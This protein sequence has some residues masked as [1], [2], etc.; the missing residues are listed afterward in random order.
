MKHSLSH[1]GNP[2]LRT[3][4]SVAVI[5]A[6]SAA[7]PASAESTKVP[8]HKSVAATASSSKTIGKTSHSDRVE[9]RIGDLRSKLKITPDQEDKWNNVTEVMRENAQKLDSLTQTRIQTANRMT[10]V[11]DLKSYSQIADA[12]AEGLKKFIPAFQAL[13]DSMSDVQ[14]KQADAMFQPGQRRMASKT[15]SG[16]DRS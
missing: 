16:K 4:A 12:H 5:A 9:A 8:Q 13:Y 6:L 14:K 7:V 1:S 10:A 11:E 3:A 2:L 15:P